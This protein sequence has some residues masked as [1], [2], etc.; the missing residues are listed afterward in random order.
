MPPGESKQELK[1]INSNT[2]KTL[3]PKLRSD[4]LAVSLASI[5]AVAGVQVAK[6]TSCS[7]SNT[8][9]NWGGDAWSYAS[10]GTSAGYTSAGFIHSTSSFYV[11]DRAG[12]LC[13]SPGNDNSSTSGTGTSYQGSWTWDF[14]NYQDGSSHIY[15]AA[16]GDTESGYVW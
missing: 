6:A 13:D 8:S 5:T 15:V 9:Y 2:M 7:M 16:T 11:Y 14:R 4:I 12:N 10:Y 1:F 3:F